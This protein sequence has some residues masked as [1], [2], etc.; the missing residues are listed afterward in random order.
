M[1][2][3]TLTV[4]LETTFLTLVTGMSS[5]FGLLYRCPVSVAIDVVNLI[6]VPPYQHSFWWYKERMSR[7]LYHG[8]GITLAQHCYVTI[9]EKLKHKLTKSAIDR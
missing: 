1:A 9:L 5:A 8:S 7:P 6:R 2:M 4:T 3:G